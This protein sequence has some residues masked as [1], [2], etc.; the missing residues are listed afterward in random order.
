MRDATPFGLQEVFSQVLFR[1]DIVL[2]SLY[3]SSAV[4]G[5]Y[6]ASYR[7]LE[8]SLFVAWSVA[9]A[10]MPMFSYLTDG[11]RPSLELA[12]EK[13]AKFLLALVVP[14]GVTLV[15]E[16]EG[17][18]DLIYGLDRYGPSVAA[19]QL[20]GA[21]IVLYAIGHLTGALVLARKKGGPF[22]WAT[23]GIATLNIALNIALIPRFSLNG[24]AA[25]TLISEIALATIALVLAR[26]V[27]GLVRPVAIAGGP[28]VAGAAMALAM[29]A[30]PGGVFVA[31]PIGA[32]AYLIV[33]CAFELR[34]FQEDAEVA[35]SI[36]QRRAA[37]QPG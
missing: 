19:L 2:L 8:A 31:L 29:L 21:T 5:W 1:I 7:L 15:A 30:V 26:R 17:L 28:L 6:G 10:M 12:Y 18:I 36:L 37:K 3:T 20:L 16:A 13:S 23:A 4:V 14:I 11:T 33:L 24:A 35:R 9:T 34:R 25:A 22:V 32:A 27:L